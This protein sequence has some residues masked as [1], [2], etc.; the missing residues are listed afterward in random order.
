MPWT[1]MGRQLERYDIHFANNFHSEE[2]IFFE[3]SFM[4]QK[5]FSTNSVQISIEIA[6]KQGQ[7][8]I[9]VSFFKKRPHFMSADRYPSTLPFFHL[10]HM[11]YNKPDS[12][13]RG[14]AVTC[15]YKRAT[16]HF[17]KTPKHQFTGEH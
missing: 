12:L 14:I 11:L 4:L 7:S 6:K 17:R 1:Q 3:Q 9:N 15:W 16:Q 10:Q 8:I 5:H 2:I 13:C